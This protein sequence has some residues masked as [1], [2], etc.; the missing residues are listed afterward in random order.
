MGA[1]A[2]HQIG[3]GILFAEAQAQSLD[4]VDQ[5]SVSACL[6][7]GQQVGERAAGELLFLAPFDRAE[8]W[9]NSRFGG[10]GREQCLGEAVD[11]LD[12]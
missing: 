9:R 8:A 3:F 10:K 1:G 7:V 6:G 2:V 11:R 5:R 4:V 12:A